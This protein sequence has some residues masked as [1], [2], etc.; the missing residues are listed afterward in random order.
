MKEIKQSN[1]YQIKD[2][3]QDK[4]QIQVEIMAEYF[5]SL[6]QETRIVRQGIVDTLTGFAL[7]YYDRQIASAKYLVDSLIKSINFRESVTG[8][9]R[10][11]ME[12][13]GGEKATEDDWEWEG[14]FGDYLN[15][16]ASSADSNFYAVVGMY[17]ETKGKILYAI[18]EQYFGKDIS[19]STLITS[20]VSENRTTKSIENIQGD[21]VSASAGFLKNMQG[22]NQAI[23]VCGYK[24]DASSIRFLARD[25]QAK[26]ALF[27]K[28]EEDFGKCRYWTITNQDNELIEAF[29]M[30]DSI[31]D[32][33]LDRWKEIKEKA[34]SLAID[35]RSIRKDFRVVRDEVLGAVEYAMAYQGLIAEDGMLLGV[36]A[37]GYDIH[38]AI[39]R[40]LGIVREMELAIDAAGEANLIASQKAN[41]LE[42]AKKEADVANSAK[43]KFLANMSHE[44]RTPMNGIVGM[45]ELLLDTGLTRE[46][47]EYADTVHDSTDALLT[48]INDILDFSKIEAG[49]MKMENINFDLRFTVENTTDILAIKAHEKRLELSCFINPEVPFLLRGDPGR[50]RQILINLTGNAIKFTNSGEIGISVIKA[51]ETESHVTVRFNVRDTGIG[52]P[53]DRMDQ[54]FKSFSQADSSTTRQHGGTGLGLAISKQITGLM[55]G[56]IGVESK[57][58]SGSTFWFTAVMEKQSCDQQQIPIELGDI[59]NMRV[60]VVD[61]HGTNRH[62]FRKYLESWYCR[63]EEAI[64]AEEAM[65]KLR[66]AV[67]CK[68]SFKIALLDYCM[69]EVDGESL[70]KEIKADLQFKDLILVMLTSIGSRGDA[71]HF[72][73]LGFAAYLRKPIKQSLLLE[74]LRIVTGQSA[75]IEKE[76]TGQIVTQYTIF[77]SHKQHIWIL[78]VEDNVIN[79][80]VALRIL[81]KK[82]GYHVEVVANGKE[83]VKSLERFDYDLVL[84]DC[85]MPVMDGYEA[86]GIIRN[87]N[88]DVRNHNIPIIAMTANAIEGDREKCLDAGMDDYISKPVNVMKLSDAID[89]RLSNIKT[90]SHSPSP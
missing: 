30:P 49:K 5:A 75:S 89:R 54:L 35:G 56:Q 46:Q 21:I 25:I 18:D 28:N 66:E 83:A 77:E 38:L 9:M 63:V 69:P 68:D 55:G 37:I 43:S 4:V 7:E 67:N 40:E 24:T 23:L 10:V 11:T 79:Q 34:G 88:S 36:L 59:K 70:C 90:S 44:I 41:E 60:L 71:E 47:R 74:C 52:I 58:G 13:Y 78:L 81:G 51:E 84:M 65:K 8:F 48:I 61:D 20:A 53:A 64:S 42:I 82:L 80:K 27:V 22:V 86:T 1:F 26:V 12:E 2:N 29:R 33:F 14:K 15:T 45:T 57:E 50:L 16:L 72:K 32:S 76:T 17:G 87:L 73:R 39:S 31:R 6:R 85:Q 62:A 19:N 3:A